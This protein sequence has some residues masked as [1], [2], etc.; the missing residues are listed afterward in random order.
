MSFSS[1]PRR[2]H[3]S[4][5]FV[6]D[7]SNQQELQRLALQDQMLTAGMGGVLPEQAEPERFETVLDVGCGTGGWLIEAAKTY[8]TMKRLVGVDINTMMV[9]YARQQAEEQQVADR[10]EFHTMDA[11]R[12]LEFPTDSFDLVNQRMGASYLRKWDWGKLLREYQR[13]SRPGAVIRITEADMVESNSPALQQCK[14]LLME[15]LYQAG[16][17]FTPR[18]D[19]VTSVLAAQLQKYGIQRVQT[20]PHV[21]EF[22]PGTPEGELFT[23]D[24]RHGM[25]TLVP[26]MRKWTRVPDDYEQIYQRMLQEVQQPGFEATWRFVTAWGHPLVE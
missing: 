23:A 26:F 19:G 16:H 20:R 8:P 4:T 22:R 17:L 5:Y 13:V 1:R 6:Q 21:L 12:M 24:M 15:A 11:L 3:P 7:R 9:G 14:Q 2:E 10:V 25:R 18:D